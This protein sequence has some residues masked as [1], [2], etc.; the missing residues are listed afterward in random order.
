MPLPLGLGLAYTFIPGLRL[1]RT[2]AQAPGCSRVDKMEE[3]WYNR[4][5]EQCCII[6]NKTTPWEVEAN[7][8][9]RSPASYI[10][11]VERAIALLKAFDI[12]KPELGVTELSRVLGLHKS[13]VSRIL[14]T[15]ERGGLVEQNPETGKYRLGV[16]LIGLG[17][18]VVAHADVREIARPLLRRL[19]EETQETVNLAVLDGDEV[20]NIEQMLPDKRQVKNIGWVGRRTPLHCVSTGKVLLAYLPEEEIERILAKG[21]SRRTDK[22]I[23]D[24]GRLR[25]E[26]VKIRQQGYATGLEELEEG[27]NAVAAPVR[28]HDGKVIAAVSVSGPSYRVSLENIPKLAKLTIR[29]AE[30][31]SRRLGFLKASNPTNSRR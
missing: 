7:L 30:E 5:W 18:L 22:T 2:A 25:K 12:D 8:G 20:I 27:L 29:T 4:N 23:T 13:T 28:N 6:C 15:L 26:L 21:L 3:K 11:S 1:F 9:R 19:A 24:P 31:I 17:A 14:A 16:A 10:K